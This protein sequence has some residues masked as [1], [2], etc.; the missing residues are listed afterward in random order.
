VIAPAGGAYP[1]ESPTR[2]DECHLEPGV[3][4]Q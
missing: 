4:I 1:Y 3:D 2:E